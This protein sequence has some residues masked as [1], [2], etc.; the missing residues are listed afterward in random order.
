MEAKQESISEIEHFFVGFGFSDQSFLV[1]TNDFKKPIYNEYNSAS[2]RYPQYGG[3][4]FEK[5]VDSWMRN[6]QY[7]RLT[8]KHGTYI[9]EDFPN[10]KLKKKFAI[11]QGKYD[12]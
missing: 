9:H 4:T 3:E 12:R 2:E 1:R 5:R 10:S 8:Y 11:A 7:L 6:H